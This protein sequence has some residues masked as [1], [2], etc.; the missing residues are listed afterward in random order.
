MHYP[1]LVCI[2]FSMPSLH[3]FTFLKVLFLYFFDVTVRPK[4][5]KNIL[6][7]TTTP[8]LEMALTV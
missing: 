3:L 2:L 6:S 7:V 4:P 8:E 5:K 1:Y